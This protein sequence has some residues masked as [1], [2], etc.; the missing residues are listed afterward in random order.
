MSY[1]HCRQKCLQQKLYPSCRFSLCGIFSTARALKRDAVMVDLIHVFTLRAK[2]NLLSAVALVDGF[3]IKSLQS[4]TIFPINSRSSDLNDF[5]CFEMSSKHS[6][7]SPFMITLNTSISTWSF[8]TLT[9]DEYI[10]WRW[11]PILLHLSA[12]SRGTIPNA[13]MPR[14]SVGWIYLGLK[15]QAHQLPESGRGKSRRDILRLL[16]FN[17][18]EHRVVW[19]TVFPGQGWFGDKGKFF[20][21]FKIV[22]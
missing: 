9:S 1:F 3:T 6:E 8:S 5:R 21:F 16:T 13:H 7:F 15:W 17:I 19:G 12:P 4:W 18:L 14:S 11:R 2:E 10:C 22:S 20:S